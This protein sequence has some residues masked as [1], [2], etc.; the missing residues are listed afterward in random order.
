[1]KMLW[2][3]GG[4]S[5]SL[6]ACSTTNYT[7]RAEFHPGVKSIPANTE[8]T[9]FK[10]KVKAYE[11]I[12]PNIANIVSLKYDEFP[13]FQELELY[14]K[15]NNLQFKEIYETSLS[16]FQDSTVE[17]SNFK[18]MNY[19]HSCKKI[20]NSPNVCESGKLEIGNK[21][22]LTP[23]AYYDNKL[24]IVLNYS[25]LGLIGMN[26]YQ[27]IDLPDLY[28][29][30]SLQTLRLSESNVYFMFVSHQPTNVIFAINYEPVQIK[31]SVESRD[32]LY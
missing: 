10:F 28:N 11:L 1:M 8:V 25:K 29:S 3:I 23:V 32:I 27:G 9:M 21:F 26:H 13:S 18:S 17:Y 7:E 19:N 5:L 31:A 24:E 20:D 15:S 4:I 14:M 2:F 22:E 30:S 16:E 12:E 6:F